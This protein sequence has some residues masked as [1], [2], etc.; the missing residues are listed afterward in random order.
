MSNGKEIE[1][2]ASAS[3]HLIEEGA[4]AIDL[5]IDNSGDGKVTSDLLREVL[6]ELGATYIKDDYTD[7][8]THAQ[9]SEDKSEEDLTSE[10][11]NIPTKEILNENLNSKDIGNLTGKGVF[12]IVKIREWLRKDEKKEDNTNE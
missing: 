6:E 7:G 8:H 4:R 9:L 11:K 12:G 2:S 5:Q 1:N 10:D 3:R